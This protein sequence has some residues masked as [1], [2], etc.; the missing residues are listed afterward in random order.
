M[1]LFRLILVLGS[2]SIFLVCSGCGKDSQQASK[3]SP[4]GLLGI[5]IVQAT[6][7]EFG[8]AFEVARSAGLQFAEISVAWD[9]IEFSPGQFRSGTLGD[10]GAFYSSQNVPLLVILSPIDTTNLRVPSD[11]RG[12]SFASEEMRSRFRAL[13]DFAISEL[14]SV[15]V[16][17]FAIGNEVDSYL[18]SDDGQWSDYEVFLKDAIDYIH[19]K[20]KD[21]QVGTIFGFDGIRAARSKN[22]LAVSDL[23]MTTYYPLNADFTVRDVSEVKSDFAQM[24][25]A[26]NGQKLIITECG[27]PTAT[28]LGSSEQLQS[29][30][31]SAVF[32][33]W[34]LYSNQI[35]HLSFFSLTDYSEDYVNEL[36]GYYG[37][38]EE[39]FL[40]Y[41]G[42]L[43]IRRADGSPKPALETLQRFT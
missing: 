10:A 36:G 20:R 13:L 42:S 12:K 29:E 2:L 21:S 5:E 41:L 22:L 39:K 25:L 34:G 32:E 28:V 11:L 18:G 16:V 35:S 9:E 1:E 33:A 3:V 23:A 14:G 17:A 26:V 8:P 27:Y 37:L 24:V 7:E 4:K 15:E 40:S 38:R 31:I 43:G 6:D 19:Q 30:F